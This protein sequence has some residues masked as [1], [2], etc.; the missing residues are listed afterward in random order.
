[1]DLQGSLNG[2]LQRFLEQVGSPLKAGDLW[3]RWRTRQRLEQYQENLLLMGHAGYLDAAR[4]ALLYVLKQTGLPFGPQHVEELMAAWRGLQ[5]FPDVAEGLRRLKARYRL[6][7]LSNG[8][9]P[10][11]DYLVAQQVRFAF[12]AVFS[13]QEVGQFKPHPA[14]YR[15]AARM[16]QAEPEELL[17]VSA[18]SFDVMG[19]RSCGYRAAWV[20]REGLPYEETPYQPDLVVRDFGELATRLGC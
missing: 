14:V 16:L 1:M 10:F 12:D 8:E 19:A 11:L 7:V 15:A 2:P 6:V 9:R 5:P 18:N 13:V 4:R 3:A 20:N 17:M